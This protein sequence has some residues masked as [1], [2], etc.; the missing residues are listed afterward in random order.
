MAI[1]TF[2]ILTLMI[3]TAMSWGG[4]GEPPVPIVAE[5]NAL[6]KTTPVDTSGIRLR[7]R[8]GVMLGVEDP[9][10][11][12]ASLGFAAQV[13]EFL[14]LQL[15]WGKSSHASQNV[16]AAAFRLF[17]PKWPVGPTL[18]LGYSSGFN[19]TVTYT[20]DGTPYTSSYLQ[21]ASPYATLGLDY[22]FESGVYVSL[23]FN[24]YFRDAT[25]SNPYFEL[26]YFL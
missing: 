24:V 11:G 22:L 8:W 12:V 3:W 6:Q 21:K 2:L 7:R 13:T 25:K 10:R 1:K 26:G 4:E 17:V 16:V 5:E 14:R 15:H 23:G 19:H 9:V 20:L 18:G